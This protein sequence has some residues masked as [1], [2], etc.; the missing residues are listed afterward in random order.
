MKLSKH[1]VSSIGRSAHSLLCINLSLLIL[2]CVSVLSLL[3]WIHNFIMIDTILQ[4]CRTNWGWNSLL[5]RKLVLM[6]IFLC[7]VLC[8]VSFRSVA[9]HFPPQPD[10]FVFLIVWLI[11]TPL[12]F[13]PRSI[14]T[15]CSGMLP[16]PLPCFFDFRYA[17]YVSN[18]P[19]ISYSLCVQEISALPFLVLSI[20]VLLY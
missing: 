17:L 16:A 1:L 13:L 3:R 18:S 19:C 14:H 12:S 2:M 15:I 4:V 8:A 9:D 20:G 10:F 5:N 6:Y 7:L 11:V